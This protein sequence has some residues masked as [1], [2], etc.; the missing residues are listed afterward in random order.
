MM[1][2]IVAAVKMFRVGHRSHAHG[3]GYARQSGTRRRK[4]GPATDKCLP[5]TCGVRADFQQSHSTQVPTQVPTKSRRGDGSSAT[6][7]QG[8]DF[9]NIGNQWSRLDENEKPASAK[10]AA[11][12]KVPGDRRGQSHEPV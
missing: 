8:M 2:G 11:M 5:K 6:A 9:S 7:S 12:S 10:S 3:T 1:A 4:K